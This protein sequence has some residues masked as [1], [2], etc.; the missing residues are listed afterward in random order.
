MVLRLNYND[1]IDVLLQKSEQSY[2]SA[3]GDFERGNYD[4]AV[5]SLYYSAFQALSALM[6]SEGLNSNKHSHVRSYLNKEL[7]MKGKISIE[8]GRMYNKLMDNRDDADYSPIVRFSKDD[9]AYYLTKVNDFN[10]SINSLM[11]PF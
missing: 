4:R 10:S 7:V 9:V 2:S 6:L 11:N 8:L 3:N 1:F 5:S